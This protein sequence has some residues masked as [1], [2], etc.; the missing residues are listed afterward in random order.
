MY[1]SVSVMVWPIFLVNADCQVNTATERQPEE[2]RAVMIAGIPP[3]KTGIV[4]NSFGGSEARR[5]RQPFQMKFGV[6]SGPGTAQSSPHPGAASPAPSARSCFRM[7]QDLLSVR[8]ITRCFFSSLLSVAKALQHLSTEPLAFPYFSKA[9]A[10]RPQRRR[11]TSAQSQATAHCQGQL[12]LS[13]SE[14]RSTS[15]PRSN[16][17][18]HFFV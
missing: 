6:H 2:L 9:L 4:E 11:P 16:N 18:W 8:G 3:S 13:V 12:C 17:A 1:L 5:V 15:L 10:W 14:P 7:R